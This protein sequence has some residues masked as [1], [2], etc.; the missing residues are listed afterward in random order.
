MRHLKVDTSTLMYDVRN[1]MYN[2]DDV[3]VIMSTGKDIN[4]ELLC[5]Y[6]R[7]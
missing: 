4:C 6:I 3:G 1:Q 7:H 5:T 2:N